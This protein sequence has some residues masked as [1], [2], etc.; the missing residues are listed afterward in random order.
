MAE[1][2][3]G[4]VTEWTFA[5]NNDFF[6]PCDENTLMQSASFLTLQ[7]YRSEQDLE[8]RDNIIVKLMINCLPIKQIF[9]SNFEIY[10][11][12]IN[13]WVILFLATNLYLKICQVS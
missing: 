2:G 9:W 10:T 13:F 12:T 1:A 3:G 6:V 11:N 5:Y 4:G 7:Y 8:H